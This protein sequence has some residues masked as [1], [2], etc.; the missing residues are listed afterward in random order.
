MSGTQRYFFW[1][2]FSLIVITGCG[3]LGNIINP[4]P[5]RPTPDIAHAKSTVAASFAFTASKT[6]PDDP[7]PPAPKP[8]EKCPICNGTGKVGDGKV[9]ATCGSCKGTGKVLA[10]GEVAVPSPT[11]IPPVIDSR[12][13]QAAERQVEF[14][15]SADAFIATANGLMQEISGMR[16]MQVEAAT[17]LQ[18]LIEQFSAKVEATAA[19]AE[20]IHA[21]NTP[22]A[23]PPAVA[24]PTEPAVVAPVAPP[25][26][27]DRIT[28]SGRTRRVIVFTNPTTCVICRTGTEPEMASLL[29]THKYILGP[30]ATAHVE[31]IYT[32]DTKKLE[33]YDA[34]PAEVA[35]AL[36]TSIDAQPVY[37]LIDAGG[38]VKRTNYNGSTTAADLLAKG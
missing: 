2:A 32:D 28:K 14:E 11:D 19:P 20:V 34:T 24:V 8:G 16:D 7:V 25:S 17:K 29:K 31:L 5:P 18:T 23:T 35:A 4:E 15:K 10:P 37:V 3:K 26:L 1:L 33:R 12:L 22:S 38:V 6:A 27:L 30:S 13:E 21:E 36:G 9:F